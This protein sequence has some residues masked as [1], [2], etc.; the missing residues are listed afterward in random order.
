MNISL[1]YRTDDLKSLIINWQVKA[2]IIGISECRLK[3][4]I[5]FLNIDIGGFIFEYTAT[6]PSK[7]GTFIKEI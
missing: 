6:E 3:E 1:P 7:G 4:N 5:F 2:K